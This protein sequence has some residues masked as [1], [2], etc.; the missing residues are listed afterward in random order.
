MVAALVL[1]GLATTAARAAATPRC[2]TSQLVVWL[3]TRGNGT[4]GSTY[5]N[6]EFT[7][8][9]GHRCTL[10]GYPGVSG[11]DL[12]GRRLGTPAR[13]NPHAPV[14]AVGLAPGASA[15]AVLQITDT[16]VFPRR[17]CRVVSA[18]GLRVYPPAQIRSK[19]V[20]FPFR[21]C[22]RP[23]PAYLHVEAVGKAVR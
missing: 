18:G 6:L 17:S 13:R 7:N 10:L 16:G 21:A 4:A 14:R 2:A 12:R 8:L 11:V 1:A 5:Y 15:S 3:D 19:V 9:S 23:G 22:S 20:P